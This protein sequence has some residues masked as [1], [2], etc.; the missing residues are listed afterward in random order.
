MQHREKQKTEKGEAAPLAF[1]PE[2]L[3]PLRAHNSGFA[4]FGR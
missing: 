3:K 4:A 1:L 2:T